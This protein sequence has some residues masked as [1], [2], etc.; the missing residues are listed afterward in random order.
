MSQSLPIC[1]NKNLPEI[2]NLL[3]EFNAGK[4][5]NNYFSEQSFN[6]LAELINE[7]KSFSSNAFKLWESKLKLDIAL[8]KYQKIYK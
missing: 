5:I 8:E 3:K 1:T 2:S 4:V 7:N 6:D